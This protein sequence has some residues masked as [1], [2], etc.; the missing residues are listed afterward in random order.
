MKRYRAIRSAASTSGKQRKDK[1]KTICDDLGFYLNELSKAIKNTDASAF[2]LDGM[3]RDDK[4]YIDDLIDK[5]DS[6]D[7]TALKVMLDEYL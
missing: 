4:D 7:T 2:E 3:S 1:L 6:I 5:L